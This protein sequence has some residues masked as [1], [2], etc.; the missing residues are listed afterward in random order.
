MALLCVLWSDNR[1]I[2]VSG[3]NSLAASKLGVSKRPKNW[4]EE[5]LVWLFASSICFEINFK[6]Y[7][8]STS[9]PLSLAD[10]LEVT[11]KKPTYFYL[12][13]TFFSILAA[14]HSY[15]NFCL[16]CRERLMA[17]TCVAG[18]F[19]CTSKRW[20]EPRNSATKLREAWNR[21][22]LEGKQPLAA[23]PPNTAQKCE[24]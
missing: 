21:I 14:I 6:K 19:V 3:P 10:W 8:K 13:D 12:T 20:T 2:T 24:L 5:I 9:R 7:F 22:K 17:R 11:K 4:L 23:P 15:F 16:L 1:R 18:S